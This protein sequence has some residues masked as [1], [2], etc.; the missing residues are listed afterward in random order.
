MQQKKKIASAVYIEIVKMLNVWAGQAQTNFGE[1]KFW[2][3]SEQK[4]GKNR[5]KV[6]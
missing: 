5:F 4:H 1:R 2:W 3:C 6:L